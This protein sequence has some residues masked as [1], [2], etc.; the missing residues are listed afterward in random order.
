MLLY[1]DATDLL[2]LFYFV[3]IRCCNIIYAD[4]NT[5]TASVF[6]LGI[7]GISVNGFALIGVDRVFKPR[8]VQTIMCPSVAWNVV[9]IS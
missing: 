2:S 8:S 4:E 1:N 7:V 6:A 9:S 5:D 3:E